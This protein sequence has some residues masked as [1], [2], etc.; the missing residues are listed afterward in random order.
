MPGQLPRCQTMCTNLTDDRAPL[1]KSSLNLNLTPIQTQYNSAAMKSFK[2]FVL[3]LA[4]LSSSAGSRAD[5][6][7]PASIEEAVKKIRTLHHKDPKIVDRLIRLQEKKCSSESSISGPCLL[8]E[9]DVHPEDKE[10]CRKNYVVLFR[11]ENKVF[12]LPSISALA[13]AFIQGSPYTEG[14]RDEKETI[15]RLNEDLKKLPLNQIKNVGSLWLQNHAWTL[16]PKQNPYDKIYDISGIDPLGF[17]VAH[18]LVGAPVWYSPSPD[19]EINIDPLVS[20]THRPYQAIHFAQGVGTT[21]HLKPNPNP[22]RLIAISLPK[23]DFQKMDCDE[24]L[25]T[26]GSWITTS[27]C[28]VGTIEFFEGESDLIFAP[29]TEQIFDSWELP[30]TTE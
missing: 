23:K 17:L 4:L 28:N 14:L 21:T 19:Q 30:P 11:G 6:F 22:S 24:A 9:C 15:D 3:I 18:H 20:F 2:P 10:T 12:E 26:S 27:L 1:T 13:R 7:T 16:R 5:G 8:N 29:K 25:P